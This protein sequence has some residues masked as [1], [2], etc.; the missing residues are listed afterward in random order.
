MPSCPA[1]PPA[2][3]MRPKRHGS[4]PCAAP[5]SIA[6]RPTPRWPS[7][8]SPSSRWRRSRAKPFASTRDATS[9]APQQK[10]KPSSQEARVLPFQ[11]TKVIHFCYGHRLLEYEGKCRYLHGHNG[12][13]EVDVDARSLDNLGMVID[14]GVVNDVVKTWVDDNLDHKMLLSKADPVIAALV[15]LDE[16]LF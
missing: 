8:A 1:R 16:P 3:R 7:S 4:L 5:P 2:H 6:S 9:S 11:V 10:M 12:V 14:F 13:L 15:A